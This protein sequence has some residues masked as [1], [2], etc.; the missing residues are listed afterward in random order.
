MSVVG[1]YIQELRLGRDLTLKDV[2]DE[3]RVSDRI[4]SA[5][6]K[7]EHEPKVGAFD[8]LLKFLSGTWDDVTLLVR[9]DAT[10]E[11]ARAAARRRLLGDDL[12][13]TPEQ[14]AFLENLTPRQKEALL[15][16]AREM[17]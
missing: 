1:V 15:A 12:G 13:F 6:E 8:A 16:V 4:V 17:R 2:A 9:D 14:R 10:E 7:G 5:W 3:I 11:D